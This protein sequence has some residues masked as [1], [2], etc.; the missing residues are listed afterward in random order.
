MSDG[1]NR[2]VPHHARTCIAH[3]FS[4]QFLHV[5]LIAMD[6]ALLASRFVFAEFAMIQTMIGIAKK[7]RTF[8]A[9]FDPSTGLRTGE[10]Q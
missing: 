4:H 9:Y 3:D 8:F 1:R 10:V 7:G 6:G 2:V 5:R